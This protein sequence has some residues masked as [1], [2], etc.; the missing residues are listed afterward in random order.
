MRTFPLPL[1]LLTYLLTSTDAYVPVPLVP[2]SGILKKN[3]NNERLIIDKRRQMS[4][5][6]FTQSTSKQRKM[7]LKAAIVPEEIGDPKVGVLFLNLGGP[8]KSTD[9]EGE[10]DDDGRERWSGSVM[11]RSE[12]GMTTE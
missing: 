11:R 4:P 3:T 8:E 7:E 12:G 10:N 9:V 2:R 6:Q 1:L 5:L